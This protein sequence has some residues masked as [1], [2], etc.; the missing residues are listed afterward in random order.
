MRK[1]YN[2]IEYNYIDP[3]GNITVLVTSPVDI[4]SQPEVADMIMKTEPTCEQVG[5]V[6]ISDKA[7][8]RLRMAGGEFC[9]NATM[10]AAALL[11]DGHDLSIGSSD[12]I[13][14][15][16]SGADHPVLVDITRIDD[17]NTHMY[18]GRVDMPLPRSVTTYDFTYKGTRYTLPVVESDGITHIILFD[19]ETR[20]CDSDEEEAIRVWCGELSCDALGIMNISAVREHASSDPDYDTF[21]SLNIRPLVYVGG[22]ESLFWERSCASGTTAVG[23][24]YANRY[25]G[26][27]I[28]ITAA[29]PGGVLTAQCRRDGHIMLCGNV[30]I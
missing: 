13:R 22:Q 19:D 7:D 4:I 6:G 30:A 8:I 1:S 17:G 20:L 28:C 14:V 26:S 25:G 10:S 9:G 2:G 27:G 21:I 24:Y 18:S 15:E 12:T 29:G 11:C 3:T 23:A 5:F 16:S